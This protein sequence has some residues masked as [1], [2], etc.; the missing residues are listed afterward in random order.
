MLSITEQ[1]RSFRTY[2][3]PPPKPSTVHRHGLVAHEIDAIVLDAV[4]QHHGETAAALHVLVAHCGLSLNSVRESLPRLVAAERIVFGQKRWTSKMHYW[5]VE[6]KE[7]AQRFSADPEQDYAVNVVLLGI[8]DG[9]SST[10]YVSSAI[11]AGKDSTS[12]RLEKLERRGLVESQ[13]KGRE[14]LWRKVEHTD[15]EPQ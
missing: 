7:A 13:R 10:N 5:P 14:K 1:I 12:R 15:K 2:A 4:Q 6:Q 3:P 11:G 8:G 9:W